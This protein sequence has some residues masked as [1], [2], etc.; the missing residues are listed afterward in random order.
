MHSYKIQTTDHLNLHVTH[1]YKIENPKGTL[2]IIHGL[3]EHQ[4]R[5]AHVAKFYSEHGFN[6]FSYD[7]RGHGKSE[8]KRGHS[9][10]IEFNLD[11]LERVIQTIPKEHLFIYG[12]SFGGN[13]LANFLLRKQPNYLSGAILSS[14]W[15]ELAK[16]PNILEFAMAN[17]MKKIAPS[18]TQNSK[19]DAKL[20]S[21]EPS[22]CEA[23][24]TD[25]L[26][27][28]KISVRLFS[29]FYAAGKWAIKNADKLPIETLLVHGADDAI[30]SSHGTVE[31]TENSKGLA[32]CKIFE[33][34]KHE[35]HNDKTHETLFAYTLSWLESRLD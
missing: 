11:D 10:G 6:V 28:D 22:V 26:N 13:V 30:I 14:A 32:K 24:V 23:Y 29:D 17:V 27:H 25:P 21:N 12:H 16:Q 19:I 18:F 9:P 34:T 3:G 33:N 7:Q 1:W 15:L 35:P 20:L 4:E 5:Y 8:G 2:C 31:F